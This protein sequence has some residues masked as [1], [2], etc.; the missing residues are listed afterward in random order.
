MKIF[1][2]F[3]SWLRPPMR[4]LEAFP[5]RGAAAPSPLARGPHRLPRH[6]AT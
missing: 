2:A 4:R 6:A 3:S 5:D 1:P